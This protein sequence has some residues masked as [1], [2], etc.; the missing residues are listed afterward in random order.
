MCHKLQQR[1]RLRSVDETESALTAVCTHLDLVPQ[2][3]TCPPPLYGMNFSWDSNVLGKASIV[4]DGYDIN[5]SK[6]LANHRSS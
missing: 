2:L 1:L 5:L 6:R 4:D 3:Y